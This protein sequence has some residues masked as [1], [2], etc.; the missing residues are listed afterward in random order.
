MS[1]NPDTHRACV[2]WPNGECLPKIGDLVKHKGKDRKVIS[3]DAG[4]DYEMHTTRRLVWLSP[5]VMS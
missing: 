1:W 3:V 4:A 5:V 2:D